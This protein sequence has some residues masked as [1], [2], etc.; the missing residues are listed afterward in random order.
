M[1]KNC[2]FG[3]P[4]I[5]HRWMSIMIPLDLNADVTLVTVHLEKLASWAV[6]LTEAISF[7]LN[8]LSNSLTSFFLATLIQNE[9]H[10]GLRSIFTHTSE[11]DWMLMCGSISIR[12]VPLSSREGFAPTDS[13]SSSLQCIAPSLQSLLNLPL[14]F[15]T[16]HNVIPEH[17]SPWRLLSYLVCQ[18]VHCHCTQKQA[19]SSNHQSL[20]LYTSPLA[21]IHILHQSYILLFSRLPHRI[22][23]HML[24][25]NRQRPCNPFWPSLYFSINVLKAN[26]ASVVLFPG[27]KPYCCSLIITTCLN[28]ASYTLSYAFMFQLMNLRPL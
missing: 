26:I 8:S 18:P 12:Y 7:W 6:F 19:Q 24:F 25:P 17:H 14:T 27:M 28:L 2:C 5:S 4:H 15:T 10:L 23:R 22:P 9:N 16:D 13:H 11:Q 20:L 3:F 21:L 1:R